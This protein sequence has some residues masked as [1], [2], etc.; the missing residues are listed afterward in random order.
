M[1]MKSILLTGD[2]Q[3]GK[4]TII[5][6]VIKEFPGSVCG[7]RTVLDE[8]SV[9]RFYIS[10]V[11]DNCSDKHEKKYVGVMGHNNRMKPIPSTFES[12]GV[13]ILKK[14]LASSPDL[15]IMD[16]LGIFENKAPLFQQAVI[17][18]FNSHIPILG[19]LK[20]KSSP[21]LDSFRSRNDLEIITVT[22]EN[23][24]EVVDIVKSK[25]N[26]LS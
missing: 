17:H 7:F 11:G 4:S 3:V 6:Q 16:E 2:V 25:V 21:F 10:P 13:D 1:I 22:R 19:V 9:R 15:I 20:D 26:M 18:C 23:R 5:N 8:G 12:I 14:C 24:D